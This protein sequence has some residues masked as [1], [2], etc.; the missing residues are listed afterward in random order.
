[1]SA[2]LPA[3]AAPL[4][5]SSPAPS[6][7]GRAS[8]SPALLLLLALGVLDTA[9][10]LV[11]VSQRAP[12]SAPLSLLSGYFVLD[13]TSLLFVLLINVIFLSVATYIWSRVRADPLLAKGIGRYALFSSAFIAASNLAV[14]SN[15]LLLMWALLEVTTLAAVPLIWHHGSPRAHQA[16]WRYFLFSGI[17]LAL[18][19]LGFACLGH[20]MAASGEPGFFLGEL[21]EAARQPA[22]LWRRIGLAL[23]FLGLGT[24]LGLAP[25]YSWLPETYD[26]APGSTT[27]LLAAVQFNVALVPVLRLLQVF[28]LAKHPAVSAELI[29]LGLLTMAVSAL[30][31]IAARSYK[32]L[33]AYASLNHAG[34]IAIGLGLGPEAAFGVV[35]YV[36]SNAFIKAL[37]FLTAGKIRSYYQT[38]KLDEVSGLIRDLPYSGIFFMVGTFALLGLPPFGSFLGEL[39]I[40]SGLLTRGYSGVFVGFC[41]T[42]TVTFVATGRA[43]FPMI[44]GETKRP[45]HWEAQPL[46]S[47]LPK[48]VILVALVA[49]GLYLPAPLKA[50]FQEVAADLGGMP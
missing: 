5:T 37:L 13:A 45:I 47:V 31:M 4:D 3:Q 26:C 24:K 48:A 46:L 20:S 15:H 44:W 23:A 39:L 41:A 36:V 9:V 50:L 49:M 11:L 21:A 19:L 33:L 29:G 2:P 35:L 40:L 30:H 34:V 10:P 7:R 22:D 28:D 16:A 17:G 25:M 32:R 42:L 12:G 38:E 43:M 27:A 6:P 8:R 18:A 14:L 1:M